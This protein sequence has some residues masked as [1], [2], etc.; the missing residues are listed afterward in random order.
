MV[1]GARGTENQG[2]IAQRDQIADMLRS[3][4][5]PQK[6]SF[7]DIGQA[8]A[9][10]RMNLMGLGSTRGPQGPTSYR[11]NLRGIQQGQRADELGRVQTAMTALELLEKLGQSGNTDA[12]FVAQ[13]SLEMAGGDTEVAN[14]FIAWGQAQ[15]ETIDK[16][17][18]TRN[19]MKF[20]KEKGVT[21]IG[22]QATEV[23][24]EK[25]AKEKD[26]PRAQA[27][28]SEQ[29]AETDTA[30]ETID[31]IIKK[32]D[33]W[34]AG[35]GSLL[36]D[37]PMTSALEL[38]ADLETLKAIVG[39]SKLQ[40]MRSA[41]K[42]GGALGQVSEKENKLLQA[43]LG[44]LDQA[45]SPEKLTAEALRVPATSM[46]PVMLAVA[47]VKADTLIVSALTVVTFIEEVSIWLNV[48]EAVVKNVPLPLAI[49][50]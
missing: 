28:L 17:N 48:G 35:M 10:S 45:Q 12:E 9:M 20:A 38:A 19:Y 21:A 18:M 22:K 6:P 31:R 8:A 44:T 40:A 36:K 7:G 14:Q 29:I 27:A 24:K 25:R 4:S 34:S 47:A 16:T 15:P 1:I 2:L 49:T 43:V 39:F 46:S 50:K 23:F 5:E 32:I 3:L 33:N 13:K 42:T 37:V 26:L 30:K 41:S 11:E